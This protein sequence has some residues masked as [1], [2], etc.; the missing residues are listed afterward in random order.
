MILIDLAVPRD[1]DPEVGELQNVT[2]YDIDSFKI[3][4]ASPKTPGQHAEGGGHFG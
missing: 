3:D 1:I 2:L 4:V